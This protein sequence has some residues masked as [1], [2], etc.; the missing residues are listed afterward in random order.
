MWRDPRGEAEGM[1]GIPGN[2]FLLDERKMFEAVRAEL[3]SCELGCV[4]GRT[5]IKVF[6]R[7][8]W[9]PHSSAPTYA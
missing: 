6:N 2:R 8:K 1:S 4:E 7:E 5:L 9:G 3:S